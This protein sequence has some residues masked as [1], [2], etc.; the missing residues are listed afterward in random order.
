[1]GWEDRPYYRERGRDSYGGVFKWI[2]YG[3]VP[4][5]TAFGIRVRA[6]AS[7]VLF[8]GLTL[9]LGLGR[10]FSPIDTVQSMTAL[11][12]LVLLH[13]FGHCFTARWVGGDADEIIMHPLGGLA[14]ATPPRRPLPTFLTVLGGPAVN[15]II[16]VICGAFLWS[17]GY[18]VPWRPFELTPRNMHSIGWFSV[19]GWAL[20]IYVMS[21]GLLMFNLL[22]IFPLDG[23]QMLQ[24]VLWPK[25]GYYKSMLFS[26][27][28]GIVGA[29]L[30]IGYGLVD[31]PVNLFLILIAIMGLVYCIQLRRQL[32]ANGPEMYT[33]EDG[34][35]Y[36]ASIYGPR[37]SRRKRKISRWKIRRVQKLERREELE[38]QQI[39]AILAKVSAHGMQSLTWRE[40]RAL[41]KAT[42]HQRQ[43]DQVLS[44]ARR[45]TL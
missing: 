37:H 20:W 26:C 29:V 42:E 35:D 15:F 31:S 12:L 33:D 27:T 2:L 14:L 23:G 43:R 40:K 38:Q 21:Y 18:G 30:A 11:F 3:S 6:H 44:D 39:D 16:C 1:M 24:A 8:I 7:L 4:L 19:W 9:L 36:Q 45:D 34:I 32:R 28:A 10:G 22:P 41:R 13:E 25:F 5:F 17:T